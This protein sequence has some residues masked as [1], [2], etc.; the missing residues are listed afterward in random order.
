MCSSDLSRWQQRFG[1]KN[2]LSMSVNFSARHL[3]QENIVHRLESVLERS[4]L[5][6]E[7][8]KIEITESLIMTNPELAAQTLAQIK[9]LGVTL[10]LDDFG[11]GYSSLSYLRRFPIDTLKMD[12]SFVGRMDTDERDMELVRMIIMLAHTLGMEVVGEGIETDSQV[13]LLRELNCEFG[14]GYFFARPLTEDDAAEMLSAPQ[15]WN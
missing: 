9:E 7:D 11:T 15:N 6:P 1:L 4:S 8:L 14:Q 3:A 10:S 13:A 12:R 2:K 5:P